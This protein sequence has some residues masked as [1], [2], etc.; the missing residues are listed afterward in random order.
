MKKIMSLVAVLSAITTINAQNLSFGLTAG[1]GHSQLSIENNQ[2]DDKFYP[3]YNAGAKLVYSFVSHWGVSA[4]IKFSGEGGKI[5]GRDALNNQH[6][7]KYRANYIRI[8]VQ[9]I[10]FF[11]KYGDVIRPK[12]SFGPSVGY[13]LGGKTSPQVNGVKTGDLK[14]K[15]I[16]NDFDFGLNG[17]V[18]FNYRL[19]GNKWLN[20][21]IAYYHGLSNISKGA[22]S[23][24]KNKN[25]G[26]NIGVT[27]PLGTVKK[28]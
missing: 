24:F 16:F 20:A 14:T 2:F 27:L 28:R 18:G 22:S 26:I 9:G 15:E 13:L 1:F 3:S 23:D 5:A 19:G 25:I 21:D 17:A 10:Y 12:I 8:P 4:D 6:Q 11:G 7:Y